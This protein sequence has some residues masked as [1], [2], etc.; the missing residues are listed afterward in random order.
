MQRPVSGRAVLVSRLSEHVCPKLVPLNWH[1]DPPVVGI[2][3]PSALRDAACSFI[4]D[5]NSQRM[6]D[7]LRGI[8][9]EPRGNRP[10]EFESI[11]I[12]QHVGSE[13]LEKLRYSIPHRG[14]API[15]VPYLPS[16]DKLPVTSPPTTLHVSQS[17]IS[18]IW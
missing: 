12:A 14:E 8:V 10:A 11:F 15:F 6:L 2:A 17:S 16:C 5:F 4:C 1:A 3:E 13:T 9:S 7:M 18:Q